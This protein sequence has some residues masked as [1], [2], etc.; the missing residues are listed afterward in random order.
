MMNRGLAPVTGIAAPPLLHTLHLVLPF[1]V[2]LILFFAQPEPLT[3]GFAGLSTGHFRTVALMP[4]VA[5][6]G[7][8]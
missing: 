2:V 3:C 5:R 1:E 7:L 8:E 6:I 4:K